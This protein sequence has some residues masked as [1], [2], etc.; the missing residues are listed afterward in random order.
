MN[1][2]RI[3]ILI[4]IVGALVGVITPAQHARAADVMYWML[5][6]SCDPTDVVDVRIE[7]INQAGPCSGYGGSP[8]FEPGDEF[9]VQKGGVSERWRLNSTYQYVNNTSAGFVCSGFDEC[10]DLTGGFLPS[11]PWVQCNIPQEMTFAC[12]INV[13]SC[14][15]DA[16]TKPD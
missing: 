12:T 7:I 4:A 16:S 8:G 6:A 14:F 9:V 15:V 1:R 5:C 2:T 13:S 11:P 3:A 10:V